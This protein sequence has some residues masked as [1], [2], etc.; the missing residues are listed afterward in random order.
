MRRGR[1]TAI[2][3]RGAPSLLNIYRILSGAGAGTPS[4]AGGSQSQLVMPPI[5]KRKELE[6]AALERID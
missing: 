5:G 4:H 3:G 2:S 1:A 6:I